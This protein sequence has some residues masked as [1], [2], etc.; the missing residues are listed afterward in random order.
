MSVQSYLMSWLHESSTDSEQLH[1]I[2]P[3]SAG[4]RQMTTFKF[5]VQTVTTKKQWFSVK[6]V[7]VLNVSTFSFRDNL[8]SLHCPDLN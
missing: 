1:L 5:P 7:D 2:F 4:N 6:L 8:I 3:Q